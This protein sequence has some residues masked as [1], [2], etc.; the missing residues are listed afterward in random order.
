MDEANIAK[1]IGDSL[2]KS[3][4]AIVATA[5]DEKMT[6]AT[7]DITEGMSDLATQVKDLHAQIKASGTG[8]DESKKTRVKA[9]VLQTMKHAL[10]GGKD[11]DV[12]EREVKAAFMNEGIAG[13]GDELVFNQFMSDVLNVMK[14]YPVINDVAMYSLE[15]GD[16]VTFPKVLN[17]ITTNW[18]SEGVAVAKS[19]ATTASVLVQIKEAQSIVEIT[20]RLLDDSM[21]VPDAYQIVVQLIGESHAAFLE[22]QILLGTGIGDNMEGVL[23]NA[24]VPTVVVGAAF[25]NIDDDDIVNMFTTVPAEYLRTGVRGG[26]WYM[27]RAVRG[28]LMKLRTT[29]GSP[30]Y[31]ELR[32]ANPSILGSPVVDSVVLPTT[33]AALTKFIMFGNLGHF[34]VVRRKELEVKQG[35]SGTGFADGIKTIKASQRLHGKIAFT[36]AFVTGKTS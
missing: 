16:S 31:P 33:T 30:L 11:F 17:A 18:A 15:K 25:S 32:T 29:D 21:T 36:E 2:E 7:K 10:I 24:S 28:I 1:A 8:N 35:Y 12:A 23:V 22:G 34:L 5:V 13:E 27:S 20:E 6:E 4:P 26:K 19:K 14:D 3:L 9:F